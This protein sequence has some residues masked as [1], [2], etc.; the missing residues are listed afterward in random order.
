MYKCIMFKI[1]VFF[2][3]TLVRPV[4]CEGCHFTHE[5]IVLLSICVLGDFT[6]FYN[7]Y[8]ISLINWFIVCIIHKCELYM[9][10]YDFCV[11]QIT[12]D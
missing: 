12:K 11:M 9:V 5:R 8:Y 1:T 3:V 4:I 7:F 6:S 10:Y 2:M